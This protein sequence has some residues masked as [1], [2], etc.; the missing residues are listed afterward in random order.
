[1]KQYLEEQRRFLVA[2]DSGYPIS[3]VVIKPYSTAEGAQ[4]PRRRAFNSKLS[5]VRT[6]MTENLFGIWKRRFPILKALR[7]DFRLSQK[8]IV[9]TAVLFNIGQMLNDEDDDDNQVV[10]EESQVV[11]MEGGD[12]VSVRLR[13]QAERDRL[14][15]NMRL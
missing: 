1:M 10:D 15:D 8:I 3:E 12:P 2:A 5:G 11:V 14:C 9:A 6:V 7:T 4:D 13:G